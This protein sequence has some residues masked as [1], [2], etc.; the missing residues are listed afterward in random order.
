MNF[1]GRIILILAIAI[2]GIYCLPDGPQKLEYIMFKLLPNS[3]LP[4]QNVTVAPAEETTQKFEEP[5]ESELQPVLSSGPIASSLSRLQS[6]RIVINNMI[7]RNYLDSVLSSGKLERWNPKT[8]PLKVYIQA[9]AEVPAEYLQEVKNAFLTWEKETNGFV[10]FVYTNSPQNANYK[11]IF[12]SNIK[13]RNCD[14]NGLGTAAYQYFTYD[15]AGNI[16]YSIVEFSVYA[17]DGKTKWPR[18]IFYSTALHEI[19]HGLGLRGHSTD[20]RDLMY[21]VSTGKLERA[22]ISQADMTTLR[23]IY[24]IIPDITNIPFTDED[25]AGLITTSDLWGV[26]DAQ[27]AD[28]TIQKI[29]ENLQ[30]TPDNPSLFAE[31]ANA[32]R[33][34]GD[35]NSAIQ[36]YSQALKKVDNRETATYLLLD[37]ADMYLKLGKLSSAEKCIDKA[38][39]YGLNKHLPVFY[40]TLGVKYAQQKNFN[41]A[42]QVFDKALSS[43]NDFELRKM[44]YQNYRWLAYVQKDK[45]MY[46]K[47]N[48]ILGGK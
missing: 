42:S 37:V 24:S 25:K 10:R 5:A 43:T 12:P 1:L 39:T 41:K 38:A 20:S 22:T 4:S 9:G 47:Y 26:N 31:L 19:G 48:R 21:P 23:A 15:N 29:K 40:N 28:F 3:P 30:I 32:Y 2:A 13:N 7:G 27:R 18:E 35:Y 6:N 33:D 44:I 17:C 36:A 14:E 34:K 16:K 11:C 46:E 45:V 8:F